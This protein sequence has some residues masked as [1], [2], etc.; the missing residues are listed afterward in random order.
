VRRRSFLTVAGAALA[1]AGGAPTA[2]VPRFSCLAPA[3]IRDAAPHLALEVDRR[4]PRGTRALTVRFLDGG[5]PALQS[6]VLQN[7]NAWWALRG[8]IK[9]VGTNGPA[10]VRITRSAP[11]WSAYIGTE[12]LMIDDQAAPTMWLGGLTLA[13]PEASWR[14]GI[15]HETGHVLG[16][17]HEQLRPEFLRRIDPRKAVAYYARW[18]GWDAETTYLNVLTPPPGPIL[19]NAPDAVSVMCYWVPGEITRDG[20]AIPGGSDIDR[21]DADF[22]ARMYAA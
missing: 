5:G 11:I 12:H 3:P 18:Y 1:G 19:G 15:R 4:W 7:M 14:G 22:Y 6:K 10:V 21:H 2:T 9:F 17:V 8:G 20:V 13:T 16:F